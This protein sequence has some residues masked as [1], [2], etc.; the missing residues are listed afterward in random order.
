ME[1]VELSETLITTY[2][3]SAYALVQIQGITILFPELLD[4]NFF[5]RQIS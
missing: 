3:T 5:L 1:A 2:E 4:G